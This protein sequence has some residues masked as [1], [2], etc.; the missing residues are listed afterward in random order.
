MKLRLTNVEIGSSRPTE[1][2]GGR[3]EGHLL[4]GL[5]QRRRLER[6]A[7]VDPATREADL[8]AVAAQRLRPSGQQHLG[9]VRPIGNRHQH[10][11][12][13][14]GRRAG[15]SWA[16]S[17][18]CGRT[19]TAPMT[20]RRSQPHGAIGPRCQATVAPAS[21]RGMRWLPPLRHCGLRSGTPTAVSPAPRLPSTSC[22]R[23]A[24]IRPSSGWPA[25]CR[26]AARHAPTPPRA[27]S[28]WR[29]GG[30]GTNRH[31]LR[32]TDRLRAVDGRRSLP[33]PTNRPASRPTSVPVPPAF[34]RHDEGLDSLRP[35]LVC[36]QTNRWTT[37][38]PTMM[39]AS[40]GDVDPWLHGRTHFDDD[41][42]H[43]D[44]LVDRR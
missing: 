18:A 4:V 10:R 37:A 40:R 43:I 27:G 34:C 28:L 8:T 3:I 5:A 9:A 1:L 36:H 24:E 35:K 2:H 41:H 23:A 44:H 21:G 32:P 12:R 33:L 11:R 15:S 22:A 25:P 38:M 42:E 19:A 30:G 7:R 20:S 17:S 26:A 6:L 31:A 29:S 14:Q 39:A 13:P 16:A